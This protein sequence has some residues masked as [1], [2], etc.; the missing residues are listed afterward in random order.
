M[1]KQAILYLWN[2]LPLFSSVSFELTDFFFSQKP[3]KCDLCGEN[4]EN[5]DK[6]EHR[7]NTHGLDMES[8]YM[9]LDNA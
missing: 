7:K 1:D 4:F 6:E 8:A 5:W 2:C 3:Q 9:L